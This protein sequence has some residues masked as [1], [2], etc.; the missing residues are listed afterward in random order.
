MIFS[1]KD[2]VSW[3]ELVDP[4]VQQALT[5]VQSNVLY[6]CEEHVV[7]PTLA[8]DIYL[9]IHLESDTYEYIKLDSKQEYLYRIR[10]QMEKSMPIV[11]ETELSIVEEEVESI[12]VSPE[13]TETIDPL[14]LVCEAVSVSAVSSPRLSPA[15]LFP[16]LSPR[17]EDLDTKTAMLMKIREN[18]S[19]T[20]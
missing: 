11:S 13:S 12:M 9:Y 17:V 2:G 16:I 5:H 8:K 15:V 3:V 19:E 20:A 18:V 7:V 14:P 6:R 4:L 10:S 1:S